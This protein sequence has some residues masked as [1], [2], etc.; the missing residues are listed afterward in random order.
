MW[1]TVELR[2]IRVC[3]ALAEELH[4][5]RTAERLGLTR[6]RV[7][8]SLRE[9]ELKLGTKLF[10]RSSRRVALT[11]AGERFLTEVRPAYG[12]LAAVLERAGGEGELRGRLRLGLLNALP[13]PPELIE[14]IKEFETE[15]PGCTV[16]IKEL[17]LSTTYEPLR[18]GEVDLIAGPPTEEPD[19]ATG[20]VLSSEPRLLAVAAD[21]PLGDREAVTTKDIADYE[22]VDITGLV[23]PELA[24]ALIPAA[25]RI[26]A[27]DE[28]PA[29]RAPRLERAAGEHRSRKY[30]PPRLRR[31][32][33]TIRDSVVCRS[34]TS[35]PW[36][37]VLRWRGDDEGRLLHAFVEAAD[38]ARTG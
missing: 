10:L 14:A 23:P 7:S 36:K 25:G 27:A 21:H 1:E 6:S 30:R 34:P 18:R 26:G 24:P 3:L 29:A 15:H 28:A 19:L 4:F 16:E 35:P 5:G 37:T 2:E 11:A 20:P 32:V 8:Q 12:T 22:V 38:R 31:P 9:L 13:H 17:A 33:R